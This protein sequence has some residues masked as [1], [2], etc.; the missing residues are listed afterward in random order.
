MRSMTSSLSQSINKKSEIDNEIVQI[1]KKET[2]N[3]FTDSM[4]SMT[5]SL[6]QSIDKVSETDK[7]ISQAALIEKFPNTYQLCNKY[8]N[9]FALLSRKGVYPYEYMDSW[10]RFKEESLPDKESFYSE[11]N[12]EHITDE[13]YAHAQKLRS[14]FEIKN[15]GE[16]NDLYVQSDTLLLADA[17][18]N[19][20]DKCIEVYELDPAR[21]LSS[22]GSAWQACLKKTEVELELLTDNDKLI[23]LEEG[24]R[25]RMCQAAHRYA[26]A[27]NKYIKNHNKNKE[28]SY[29]EYLDANNLYGWA[30]SEKLPVGNFKWIEKDYISKFD[31]K[32]IKSYDENSDKGYILEVDVEYPENL[33]KLHSDL[34]FLPESM[35]INKCSKLCCTVQDKEKYVA[36][37]RAL[38]QALNH[39]LKLAKVY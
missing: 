26:K 8:L 38:K 23:L 29:L 15:L 9:K 2:E 17:F 37:I 31:E 28:S 16:C 1:D 32:F 33:H 13:D 5:A 36:H 3:K 20:R 34:T 18:E 21:F 30:M 12:N 14:T 4:R 27:N 10:K 39:G 11:L 22:P 7:K 19:F 6:F 35:K 24:T 25:G